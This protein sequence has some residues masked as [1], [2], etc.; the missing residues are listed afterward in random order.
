MKIPSKETQ[1]SLEDLF[2]KFQL[3]PVLRQ[4]FATVDIVH[5]VTTHGIEPKMAIE[6]L[7]QMFLHRQTTPDVLVGILSPKYGSP[8]AVADKLKILCDLDFFNAN[9]KENDPNGEWVCSIIYDL[10]DE[11]KQMLERYQFPLPMVVRPLPIEANFDSGYLTMKNSVVLNGC[12]YFDDKDMCLDHLNRSNKVPLAINFD[13][14]RSNH[15]KFIL[16]MRKADEDFAEYKKRLKQAQKFYDNSIFVMEEIEALSDTIYLTHR[17]DRRGRI[18]CTGYHVNEQGTDYHK[19][20][21]EFANKEL[22]E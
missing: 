3:L 22:V 14:V 16:P 18:Y 7:V 1:K 21:L 2:N 5:S 20:V 15:G 4:E 11:M 10:N 17:Y 8:Q 12:D 19:A 6:V 13:V 9:Q